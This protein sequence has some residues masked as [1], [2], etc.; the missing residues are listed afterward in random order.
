MSELVA[1]SEASRPQDDLWPST[2]VSK[3]VRD[4]WLND[5]DG[6]LLSTIPDFL[7]GKIAVQ[8]VT[9]VAEDL[10]TAC[11]QN[12]ITNQAS[13][14]RHRDAFITQR[15][16]EAAD[17]TLRNARREPERN[18]AGMFDRHFT[19]SRLKPQELRADALK[20]FAILNALSDTDAVILALWFRKKSRE[21][22]S[23]ITG[24]AL[25]TVKFRLARMKPK[26]MR[27][28][29]ESD[30]PLDSLLLV[31]YLL[32]RFDSEVL[33]SDKED[34]AD[35]PLEAT[36]VLHIKYPNSPVIIR[37][38][39]RLCF[40][41]AGFVLVGLACLWYLAASNSWMSLH[42]ESKRK[43]YDAIKDEPSRPKVRKLKAVVSMFSA[44]AIQ[45]SPV[46]TNV[47]IEEKLLPSGEVFFDGRGEEQDSRG[48]YSRP[49][50][51][52]T[53]KDRE[54][55]YLPGPSPWYLWREYLDGRMSVEQIEIESTIYHPPCQLFHAGIEPIFENGHCLWKNSDEV[56]ALPSFTDGWIGEAVGG[57]FSDEVP[58]RRGNLYLSSAM[59]GYI[60]RKNALNDTDRDGLSDA[61][62]LALG[63]SPQTADSDGDGISDGKELFVFGCDPK[64]K[65]EDER[66][67]DIIRSRGV[68]RCRQ[69]S[70]PSIDER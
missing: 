42:R 40:C 3:F 20:A 49:Y 62:E 2:E 63:S 6:V 17:A 7:P 58:R 30:I 70:L 39:I 43:K 1:E 27:W 23:N 69:R 28:A 50:I 9:R 12:L 15:L 47:K 38:H 19:F 16:G 5:I 8:V 4:L 13:Y 37:S 35:A 21:Q 32:F 54:I 52:V 61:L 53:A 56:L 33:H 18:I 68:G 57:F 11:H 46:E 48:F 29:Q 34:N 55:H 10:A 36:R 25:S 22:I 60:S 45:T 44:R 51:L 59:L 65:T 41:I 14:T 64:S 26:Y 31:G 66:M 67:T 24:I